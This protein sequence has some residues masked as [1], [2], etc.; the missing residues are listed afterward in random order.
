MSP[1]MGWLN[2]WPEFVIVIDASLR[3]GDLRAPLAALV[4]IL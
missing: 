4:F 1:Y 3:G 2:F